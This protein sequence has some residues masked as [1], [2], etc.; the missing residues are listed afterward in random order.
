LRTLRRGTRTLRRMAWMRSATAAGL[1]LA[2]GAGSARA[3]ARVPPPLTGNW[4]GKGSRG[5]AMSF[6]LRRVS[7]R[8]SL[9]GGITAT[10]P[11]APVLCPAGPRSAAAVHYSGAEYLG[12]GSPPISIF[13]FAPRYVDIQVVGSGQF[14]DWAGKLRSRTKMV[15]TAAGPVHQPKSCGWPQ[16]LRWV[17]RRQRRVPVAAG[18]WT[19]SFNGPEV[20]G[21]LHV[22]VTAAGHIVD[23]F[24]AQPECAAGGPA[25]PGVSASDAEEFIDRRGQFAGPLGPNTINGVDVSWTGRFAGDTLTGAVTLFDQ[26]ARP[27]HGALVA[28]FV[29]HPASPVVR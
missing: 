26:C 14:S 8:I 19:G 5:V 21:A 25:P 11:T 20:T 22:H 4:E 3:S 28:D 12:P 10:S 9:I 29:A 6:R 13:H 27:P 17:V 23:A 15:L 18:S 7:H 1:V 2:V 24:S 16:R